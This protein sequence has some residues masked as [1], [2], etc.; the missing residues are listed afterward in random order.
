[1]CASDGAVAVAEVVAQG[2]DET[3][4]LLEQAHRLSLGRVSCWS[5]TTC[6][7]GWYSDLV[8]VFECRPPAVDVAHV[9]VPRQDTQTWATS[10]PDVDQFGVVIVALRSITSGTRAVMTS[11]LMSVC[12]PAAPVC[13]GRAIVCFLSEP[14]RGLEPA[15]ISTSKTAT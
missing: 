4:Q 5:L 3:G 8:G 11:G 1:M 6:Q 9:C 2:A 15:H 14:H 13:A 7:S 10:S 12:R